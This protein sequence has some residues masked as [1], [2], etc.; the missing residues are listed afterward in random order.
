VFDAVATAWMTRGGCVVHSRPAIDDELLRVHTSRHV[1]RVAASAGKA[2]M[3]D[4]DIFT[5]PHSY[6]MHSWPPAGPSRRLS[7]RS[8]RNWRLPSCGHRGIT[9]NQTA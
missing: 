3:F 9:P 8:M 5:S 6:C 4:A 7:T 2:T 1:D